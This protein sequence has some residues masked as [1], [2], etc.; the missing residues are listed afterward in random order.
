MT[1]TALYH[2]T[3]S[4]ITTNQQIENYSLVTYHYIKFY[5]KVKFFKKKGLLLGKSIHPV[6]GILPNTWKKER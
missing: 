5:K 1:L 4:Q 6:C 3:D 2:K